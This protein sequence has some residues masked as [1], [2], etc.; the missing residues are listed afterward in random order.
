MIPLF[1]ILVG[2]VGGGGALVSGI[3]MVAKA[4]RMAAWPSAPGVVV[5][6]EVITKRD[7]GADPGTPSRSYHARVEFSYAV[8]GR[9][10]RGSRVG[11]AD[12]GGTLPGVAESV[13]RRYAA[14]KEVTVYYNPQSP[15]ESLLERTGA[16][17]WGILLVLVGGSILVG[18]VLWT[19]F[20]NQ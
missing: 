12:A 13:A 3:A 10:Y 17:G 5:R 15:G 2:A 9:Q 14:G 4:R 6:S 16:A 7:T 20:S 18:T 11:V 8:A 19:A 1:D